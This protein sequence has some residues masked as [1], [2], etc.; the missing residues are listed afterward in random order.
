MIRGFGEWVEFLS[1]DIVINPGDVIASGTCA[2]TAADSSER[3][4]EGNPKPDLFLK[5]GDI[6]EVSSKTI[7]GKLR[8]RIVAKKS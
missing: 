4:K 5:V 7:G 1:A 8:N 6:V 3:D 2:G